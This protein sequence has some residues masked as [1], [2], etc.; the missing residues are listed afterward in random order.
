MLIEKACT[1]DIAQA[2][3]AA[4]LAAVNEASRQADRILGPRPLPGTPDWEAEQ[5]DPAIQRDIATGLLQLRIE[6]ALG[7]D[8]FGTVLGLRRWGATWELVA[9]AAGVSRQAAHER[10]G[11]RVRETLGIPENAEAGL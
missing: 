4:S 3:T 8:P 2:V 9:R 11:K 10:W 7:L 6:L 1:T 5:G